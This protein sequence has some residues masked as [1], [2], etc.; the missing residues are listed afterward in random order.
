MLNKL[1]LQNS[2]PNCIKLPVLFIP[3]ESAAKGSEAN[4]TC[5][6]VSGFLPSL[7][8]DSVPSMMVKSLI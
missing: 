4:V 1:L 2:R 5:F 6:G 7:H 3:D 8:S